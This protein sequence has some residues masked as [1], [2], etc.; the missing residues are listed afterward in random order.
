MSEDSRQEKISIDF[1]IIMAI[2]FTLIFWAF[3]FA[4]I[5]ENKPTS[6]KI[7]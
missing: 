7:S 6:Y 3:A 4:G 2:A 1:H 5:K